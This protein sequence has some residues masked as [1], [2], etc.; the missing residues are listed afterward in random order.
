M[1]LKKH[2]IAQAACLLAA[3]MLLRPMPFWTGASKL[4]VQMS[5]LVAICHAV[6]LRAIDFTVAAGLVVAAVGIFRRRWFCKYACPVG[7]ILDAITVIGLKKTRWWTRWPPLGK[8]FAILTIAGSVVGYPLLLWMDPLAIFSNYVT[9]T[10]AGRRHPR[11]RGS[12]FI[13]HFFG[14]CLVRANLSARWHTGSACISK[15]TTDKSPQSGSCSRY[16]SKP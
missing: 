7:L 16:E 5:P 2:R 15:G 12:D 11:N 4:V 8:Y 6:A 1:T 14:I 3:C 13:K 10:T 9:V